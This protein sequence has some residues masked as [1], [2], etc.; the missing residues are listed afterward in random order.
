VLDNQWHHIAVQRRRADGWLWLYVDGRLEAQGDG[1][2]GDI[3]YP[4]DGVPGNFCGGPCINSDPY[5]VL[6]AEK[7]DAGPQFP[8]FAGWLDEFRLS[9]V[10]RYAAAFTRPATPFLPDA[11][12]VALYHFDEG[13]GDLIIDTPGVSGG[14]SHGVR[15]FGGSPAG[16]EWV[17]SGAPLAPG[18]A[19]TGQWAGPF[20]W[21][22]VTV[23][24]MLSPTGQVLAWDGT[25]NAGASARLW[26]PATGTFTLVPT[27]SDLVCGGHSTLADGRTLVIGGFARATFVGIRD[28]NVFDPVTQ[29]WTQAAPMAYPRWYP[30]ATTLPDGRVLATSGTTTCS[31]CIADTPEVYDP[32]TNAWTQLMN[33]RLTVPF[34]PFM[35]VLP[36]GRVVNAGSQQV[37]IVTRILDVQA[38]TWTMVDPVA[39]GGGSAAMYRPGRVVKSGSPTNVDLPSTPSVNRTWVID[40]TQPAPAWRETAPMAFPRGHHNLII[41]ADGTVL[42]V[43][44][45]RTT[46]GVDLAQAVYEA[47][48]WA[49]ETET[50]STM[51]AM[52]VPRLYHSTA[53]L[54]ADGRVL[55]AGGGRF[56]GFDQLS[57]EVYSPPSLFRGVRPTITLAP[58]SVEYGSNLLVTTPD[59]SNIAMVSL[60]RLGAVTHSFDQDQRFLNLSFAPGVGSLTVQAPA[61]A[62]LAPPGYYMLFLIN[63][64]GVPSV[65]AFVRLSGAGTDTTAPTVTITAPTSNATYTTSS[66]PLA[67]GGTAADNVGVTQVTWAND[68]GGSGSATSTTNWTNWSASVALQSG[69][70][71]LTVTARDGAGNPGTDTLTVTYTPPTDNPVPTTTGLSPAA[72]PAGGLGFMLTVSGSNFVNGAVVR[73][74]GANRTTTFA[75]SSQ[76]TAVIGVGDIATAGTAQVTVFNPTPG[77]GTS[78]AQTFT[79]SASATTTVTFDNPLPPGSSGSFLNGLFQ[80]IDF[81]TSQWRWENAYGADPTRHIYFASSSGTSRA[82]TF[83]PGPRT[84]VS[85][86]VF[87]GVAGTLTLTDSLGQTRTQAV[88]TGSMQLVTTGWTQPSTTVTVTFTAGWQLGVDDIV[89]RNP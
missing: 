73:W 88:T 64:A 54:L 89:Y 26:N 31:T 81:G 13:G 60:I 20:D 6:G 45:G 78:N 8:S 70:N 83:S 44:G 21:P 62:N 50:W 84:L 4:D 27:G 49:P 71:V 29:S 67:L 25:Q 22:I 57:A 17:V 18:P 58:S 47:E 51:A 56:Q 40:M 87:T 41:L 7:H 32:T 12:T 9:N 65:A 53:L 36:D 38:Q 23:H 28:A 85:L 46:D 66:S 37:S 59:A 76:L 69:T 14:P 34:Y 33:A 48:L 43:G 52:R 72:A 79:I 42:V 77:G 61:N 39:V 68:R 82:F 75:S 3:S 5:L 80:G 35:F 19:Q 30:T 63:E 86:R 1:P 11:N 16:P 55:A 24:M 10:L 2:D 15:R 74:N